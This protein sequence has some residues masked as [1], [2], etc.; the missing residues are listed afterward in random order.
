M[1]T[2]AQ[3]VSENIRS[4]MK[5]LGLTQSDLAK[6]IGVNQ[7]MVSKWLSGT[8][9]PESSTQDRLCK[10]LECS[11]DRLVEVSRNDKTERAL[12]LISVQLDSIE[13]LLKPSQ[14]VDD[15]SALELLVKIQRVLP[16]L[17]QDQLRNI[18]SL[19]NGYLGA[20]SA[21]DDSNAI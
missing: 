21:S 1:D 8:I 13:N 2:I 5:E 18:L 11:I 19:A 14:V 7:P 12:K 3:I 10:A 15:N 17:D 16:S 9:T 4:R 6:R 20:H